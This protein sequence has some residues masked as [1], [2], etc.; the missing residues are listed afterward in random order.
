MIPRPTGRCLR[1]RRAGPGLDVFAADG[2]SLQAAAAR[3]EAWDGEMLHL[4]LTDGLPVPA[5]TGG[6]GLVAALP[7]GLMRDER[8][9]ARQ[10]RDRP[11]GAR[12]VG[13]R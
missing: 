13:G 4:D 2:G 9:T 3:V 7:P 5:M 11:V 1:A 8:L 12:A 10:R 6:P